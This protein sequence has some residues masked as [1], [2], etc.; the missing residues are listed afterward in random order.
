MNFKIIAYA[1]LALLAVVGIS[2]H[3]EKQKKINERL[4][5][6]L[7][8]SNLAEIKESIKLGADV[9][10][11]GINTTALMEATKAGDVEFM[12]YLIQHGANINTQTE[13][14]Q[15]HAGKP[16]LSFALET[17]NLDAVKLLVDAGANVNLY[18][19]LGTTPDLQSI[20][21]SLR[22]R[23]NPLLIYAIGVKLPMP[24]IE[25]LLNS[26]AVDVNKE[27]LLHSVTALMVA[28]AVG[29]EDAV[30][31][32]LKAG[33]D[34]EITNTLDNKK[35]IDYARDAGYENIVKLLS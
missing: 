11:T 28:S 1:G 35:A 21:E 17:K 7:K 23:N 29:Y 31:A 27:S 25:A 22:Q 16:A 18:N 33:A 5:G 12:H 14:D 15:P 3:Q 19:D 8:D 26:K 34:K 30:K 4:Y 20:P 10:A 32:L 9:N 6:A 13:W 2:K 24:F